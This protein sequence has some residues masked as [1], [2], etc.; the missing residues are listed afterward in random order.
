MSGCFNLIT[1][2][3]LC[4]ILFYTLK[5][6]ENTVKST[7]KRYFEKE[8][9][10]YIVSRQEETRFQLVSKNKNLSSYYQLSP[11]FVSF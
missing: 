1:G 9:Y 8:R 7:I 10:F 6:I 3:F 11:V 5:T 2:V 4:Q